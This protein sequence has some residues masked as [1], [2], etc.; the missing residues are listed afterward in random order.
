MDM[1][2][3]VANSFKYPL[4]NWKRFFLF[5]LIVLIYELPVQIISK[6]LNVSLYLILLII[7]AIIAYFLMT[8]YQLRAIGSS[9]KGED[10]LPALNKWPQMFIDGLKVFILSFIYGIGPAIV[11]GFGFILLITGSTVAKVLGVIV[12]LIALLLFMVVYLILM[13]ALPNMA[14]Y[15]DISAGLR[16]REIYTKIKKIGRLEYF[17]IF[18]ILIIIVGLLAIASGIISLLPVIGLVIASIIVIPFSNLFT[19]RVYGLIYKETLD[20]EVKDPELQV[21]NPPETETP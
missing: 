20:E 5:G 10:E 14:Y 6:Y 1:G 11:L 2:D 7:P 13:M 16:L 17:V 12:L 8:G 19:A 9:L 3:I 21:E 15:G 4:S 18:I